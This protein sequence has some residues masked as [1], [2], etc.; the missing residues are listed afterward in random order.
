MFSTSEDVFEEPTPKTRTMNR[1]Y[2]I[3]T[4]YTSRNRS[5]PSLLDETE[6]GSLAS[7][8][9][10]Y[11]A[12]SIQSNTENTLNTNL[13]QTSTSK[14]YSLLDDPVPTTVTS[15]PSLPEPTKTT[16]LSNTSSVFSSSSLETNI[17]SKPDFKSRTFV[18]TVPES[19]R[20]INKV[21]E[22]QIQTSIYNQSETKQPVVSRVSASLPR[23]YQKTDSTRITSFVAP[24][25]FGTQST[26]V[27]SL[28]RSYTVRSCFYF[29]HDVVV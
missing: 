23:S 28:P 19:R 3:D 4:P 26:R 15:K 1:S 7:V 16:Q 29:V 14:S 18:G 2:T 9:E 27:S 13:N 17:N 5:L 21:E 11:P 20:S 25:P 24:R 10:D 22:G 12:S 8:S 6:S